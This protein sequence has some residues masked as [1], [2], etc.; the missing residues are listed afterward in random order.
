MEYE[1]TEARSPDSTVTGLD[2]NI[3][4]DIDEVQD[5]SRTPSPTTVIDK[6]MQGEAVEETLPARQNRCLVSE[7]VIKPGVVPS[8]EHTPVAEGKETPQNESVP[9]DDKEPAH[10]VAEDEIVE[11]HAGVEDL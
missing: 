6:P 3:E 4:W 11:L 9:A 5:R 7:R 10:R 1:Q 2:K 8:R